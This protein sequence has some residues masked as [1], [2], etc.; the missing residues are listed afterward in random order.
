MAKKM[1]VQRRGIRRQARRK[2]SRTLFDFVDGGAEDEVHGTQQ[3]GAVRRAAMVPGCSSMC[4]KGSLEPSCRRR[5]GG[6]DH[7]RDDLP[8]PQPRR[9][10]AFRWREG[11]A[12]VRPG[13]CSRL[14]SGR[15]TMPSKR[16]PRPAPGQWFAM[17]PW[18]NREFYGEM[19]D[20]RAG[21]GYTG[22]CLTVDKDRRQ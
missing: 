9:L 22:L 21:A 6:C 13:S 20:P 17:C 5:S 18:R 7:V 15:L 14:V 3:S 1:A 8:P 19:I 16:W 10:G 4:A 12:L 11:A 2:T